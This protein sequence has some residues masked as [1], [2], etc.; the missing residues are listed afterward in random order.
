MKEIK[1]KYSTEKIESSGL[2][3]SILRKKGDAKTY[4][5]WLIQRI[6]EARDSKSFEAAIFLQELYKKYIEFEESDKIKLKRWRGKKGEMKFWSKPDKIIIEF[7]QSR[8]KDQEPRRAKKEY[9]KQDINRMIWCLNKLRKEYNNKIPS[10][11]LG[12]LYFRGNWDSKVFTKR[13]NHQGFTHI[14]NILDNYGMIHYSGGISIIKKEIK[15]IQ[16]VLEI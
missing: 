6:K 10:R 1:E 8:S 12:E 16:E 9:S 15:E 13:T 3:K 2:D 5:G 7:A 11:K 4:S 14:L